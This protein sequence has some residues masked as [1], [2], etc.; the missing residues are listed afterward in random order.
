MSAKGAAKKRPATYADIEALPTYKLGEIIGDELI[1]SPRPA[2]RHALATTSLVGALDGPFTR[3]KNGPGGW[4]IL[5]EPELHWERQVLVPDIG[6]WRRERMPDLPH[7]AFFTVAPDWLC[8]TLSPSTAAIDRT[9]KLDVYATQGVDC[10]WLVDPV[11]R[12][13]E[14]LRRDEARWVVAENY[15]GD[16]KV[17]AVP[18]E[19]I[20]IDLA[21]LWVPE[22]R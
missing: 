4:W 13:L 22:R 18:F 14:V 8:E 3:G 7:D 9:Q 5:F 17:R 2:P 19:T 16:V 10:V 15:V 11:A 21:A 20:E 1:V 12:T 6:G